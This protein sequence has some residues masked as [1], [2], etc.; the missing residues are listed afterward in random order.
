MALSRDISGVTAEKDGGKRLIQWAEAKDDVTY[1]I[2]YIIAPQTKDYPA[3]MPVML[4]LRNRIKQYSI[5]WGKK[6]K[7]TDKRKA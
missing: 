4:R 5:F 2:M 3:Q 7:P 1:P 6:K